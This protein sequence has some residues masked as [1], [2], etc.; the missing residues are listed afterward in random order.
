[1]LQERFG[2]AIS[3]TTATTSEWDDDAMFCVAQ[4]DFSRCGFGIQG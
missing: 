2:A 3:C 1:M 4:K